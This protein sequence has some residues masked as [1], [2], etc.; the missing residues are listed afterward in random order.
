V[1]LCGIPKDR[2]YL[3]KSYWKPEETTVHILPHWNWS[4]R[5]GEKTPVFVYTNGD[6]A[7]LFLNGT[8]KGVV[9][10]D[11]KSKNSIERFRLMWNDITYEAGELVAVAYKEGVEIGRATVRTAGEA[12]KIMLTPDRR[13]IRTG[14]DDL[15]FVLIDAFDDN[16]NPAPLAMD[17][18]QLNV[19]GAGSFAGAGNGNPQSFEGFQNNVV[20]LFYGKAM[21]ILRSSESSGQ[22]DLQVSGERFDT[23]RATIKVEN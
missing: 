1:D 21:V 10:K 12:S 19:S 22:I 15:S 6:C 13:V 2:F 7:E 11:P 3:Y 4:G 9:C 16:G 17:D 18:L 20:S 23:V 5:E 14:G 8:S